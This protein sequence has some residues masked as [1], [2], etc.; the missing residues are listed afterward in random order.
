MSIIADRLSVIKP[1]PT[2]A[3]SQKATELKAE[4]RN[5]LNL[6]A[7]EPDFETPDYI[8][9]SAKEAI[10]N[11]E[12][13]Y[14]VVAGILPLREAICAKLKRENNLDYKPE[15]ISVATGGK[16]SIFNA[17]M[18]T[19]NPDDEVIIPAPY[20]V[21]YPDIVLLAGGK[22]V[23][24]SCTEKE[25]F[26]L[27]APALRKAITPKTKWLMLNSPSNP[28]GVAYTRQ[29]LKAIADVLLENPH[30][31]VMTD[32]MYEHIIYDDFKFTTIAEVE[33][34]LFDRTLTLN[35]LS[36]AFSMTGWRI[37]YAAGS[38][39]VIKAINKIQSQSTTHAAS[40]CQAA[41]VTALNGSMDFMKER[42]EIFK[43]RR[44]MVVSMLNETK[45]LKCLVPEGAF[46]V[47]PSCEGCIGKT[48]PDG[49]KIETDS[50]FVTCLLESEGVASVQ[51]EAFGLS[52]HFRISYAT[53]TKVLREAC[54]KIQHFCASLT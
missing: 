16:Q 40:M 28:T 15:Q 27:T 5:I 45:G 41:A 36:K 54:E 47:Y 33:P 43:R 19:I 1:S 9:K 30:V 31:W 50:D 8:K 53:S 22:P 37:G 6:G 32:D 10:D 3:V 49:M 14:T 34:K 29:E 35:G 23:F 13:K 25:Q 42:A 24:V 18:A 11:G 38:V 51:G 44:D 26:K 7:G 21:S 52:P 17:M 39:E 2:L 12:T 20:W 48:T 46:Y 4:G